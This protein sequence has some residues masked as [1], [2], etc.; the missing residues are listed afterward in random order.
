MLPPED[1]IIIEDQLYIPKGANLNYRHLN[2]LERKALKKDIK[3]TK[4][5]NNPLV[6]NNYYKPVIQMDT[7]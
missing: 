5:N 6:N 1:Y 3:K 2:V 4:S 7:M